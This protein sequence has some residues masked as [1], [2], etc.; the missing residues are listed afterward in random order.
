MSMSQPQT[1]VVLKAS[2]CRQLTP[3]PRLR[4]SCHPYLCALGNGP[5]KTRSPS[6]FPRDARGPTFP[7]QVE[8]HLPLQ[9]FPH[10]SSFLVLGTSLF[11]RGP[12]SPLHSRL[13]RADAGHVGTGFPVYEECSTLKSRLRSVVQ[14]ACPES[15]ANL[16][17]YQHMPLYKR[18]L[19]RMWEG[20]GC[21]HPKITL[22]NIDSPDRTH[23]NNDCR[24]YRRTLKGAHSS[25]RADSSRHTHAQKQSVSG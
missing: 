3:P 12:P 14:H 13:H 23:G 20:R 2:L 4:Q 5:V 6:S 1:E 25:R 19:G 8:S 17:F 22:K 9:M 10:H 21:I 7:L 18:F 11:A 24:N 15:S 16:R